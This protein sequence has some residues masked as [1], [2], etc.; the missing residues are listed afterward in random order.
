MV[1]LLINRIHSSGTSSSD[2]FVYQHP[3][4]VGTSHFLL[5]LLLLSSSVIVAIVVVAIEL[6]SRTHKIQI[7]IYNQE[8]QSV[9]AVEYSECI[10]AAE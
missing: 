8:A 6:V 4:K 2:P 10:S 1:N 5:L 7:Y 3:R 9:G